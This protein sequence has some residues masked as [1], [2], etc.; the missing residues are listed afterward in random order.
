MTSAV[1]TSLYRMNVLIRRRPTASREEL[2]ANW[3]ANH[4][5]ALVRGMGAA[6]LAGQPHC[7]RY[8]V[9]LF[10]P[11]GGSNATGLQW[12][13][14]A[15]LWWPMVLPK[16]AAPHG[17]KPADTF[18]EKAEPYTTWFTHEYVIIDD[19]GRLPSKANT[20]NEPFPYSRSGFFKATILL[21]TQ[22]GADNAA[23]FDHWLTVHAPNVVSLLKEVG[24]FRYVIG[25]S[26]DP[27][28]EPFAG[29]A[30][31]YFENK[32]GW[33]AFRSGSKPDGMERWVDGQGIRVFTGDTQFVGIPG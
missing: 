2:V 5:P 7:K 18:Q 3:F 6:A 13:G 30:E 1:A 19:A 29:M 26:V 31:L 16:P 33:D 27:P 25:H 14:M 24:G 21:P 32:A 8:I 20:L 11:A 17:T 10:D 15:Q 22:P 4:M 9:S 28:N 12:D 23:F